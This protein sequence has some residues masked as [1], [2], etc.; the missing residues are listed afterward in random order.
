MTNFDEDIKRADPSD[1]PSPRLRQLINVMSDDARHG[2]GNRHPLT[3]SPWW[4]RSRYALPI[5]TGVAV[6]VLGAAIINP[7]TIGLGGD[8]FAPTVRIPITYTTEN[9][10]NVSCDYGILVGDPSAPTD[11]DAE[12]TAFLREQDWSG[13]GQEIYDEAMRHPFVP[14][15]NSDLHS[16]DQALLDS[17]SFQDALF[18]ITNRIP[19]DIT[20]QWGATTDC[21]GVLR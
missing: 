3:P 21:T 20:A 5:A 13:I 4:R 2:R 1:A 19:A 9:G 6:A 8:R 17:F 18:V 14:G 12:L 16:D 10:I 15:P 11:E 7:L